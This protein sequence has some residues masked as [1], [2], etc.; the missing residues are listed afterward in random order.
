MLGLDIEKSCARHL[1][2]ISPARKRPAIPLGTRVSALISSKT[3]TFV[4]RVA[5][6]AGLFI[7][8][9][10][11]PKFQ[12]GFCSSSLSRAIRSF[13][14]IGASS[15]VGGGASSR[16]ISGINRDASHTTVSRARLRFL[17]Q[18]T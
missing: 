1:P 2:E 3:N 9:K 6:N 18:F 5:Q 17:H 16:S 15:S 13:G 14:D 7:S 11:E 4:V 10:T 12:A 8:A